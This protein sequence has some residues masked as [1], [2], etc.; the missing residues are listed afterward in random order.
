MVPFWGFR[1]P[2][3]RVPIF[4]GVRPSGAIDPHYL[5][6]LRAVV[7]QDSGII[8]TALRF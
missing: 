7:K 8:D 1:T 6:D 4:P 3:W 2:P 5:D